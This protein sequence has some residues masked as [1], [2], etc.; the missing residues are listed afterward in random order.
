MFSTRKLVAS[1]AL[2]LTAAVGVGVLLPASPA[3][4]A[5]ITNLNSSMHL[6]NYSVPA[7]PPAYDASTPVLP[8]VDGTLGRPARILMTG[9]ASLGTNNDALT[10]P[11]T[12]GTRNNMKNGAVMTDTSGYDHQAWYFQRMGYVGVINPAVNPDYPTRL[13]TPVYRII[14]YEDNGAYCVNSGLEGKVGS[15]LEMRPCGTSAYNDDLELWLI[16]SPGR[17]NNIFDTSTGSFTGAYANQY[18]SPA[19]QSAF[20]GG[21]ADYEHSVIENLDAVMWASMDVTKSTVASAGVDNPT[22]DY[23]RLE[24]L[25]QTQSPVN[26]S[27]STWNLVPM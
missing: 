9:D 18:F 26:S 5:T 15:I 1:A 22:G 27:N 2:S 25:G 10:A 7:T 3:S 17:T 16:G 13:G 21:P 19:L 6:G 8:E 14:H 20:A 11:T 23:S 4:A 24:V 12:P